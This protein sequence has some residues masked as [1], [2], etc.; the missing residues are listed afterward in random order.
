[1][2][3][4]SIGVALATVA[5]YM[6]GFLY[7]GLTSFP[8]S[9]LKAT[10]DNEATQQVLLDHFPNTGTY[11]VPGVHNETDVLN[12]LFEAGPI[13]FVNIV[14]EGHPM[15]DPAMMGQGFLLTIA[16]TFLISLLMKKAL[17]SLPAYKDRV[18]FAAM[19]GIAAVVM[20]D[21]GDAVWWSFDWGWQM[22]KALYGVVAC[23]IA[24]LVLGK[25]IKPAEAN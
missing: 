14:R 3:N 24:G 17:P 25:L 16:I 21:F 18:L 22:S 4:Q 9:P 12:R 20:V 7:W 10:N 6:W 5:V 19:F 23:L 11:L 2:K 15:E 13:V 8:Y 1:M